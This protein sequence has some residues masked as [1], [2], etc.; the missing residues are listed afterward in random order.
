M[1]PWASRK[2]VSSSAFLPFPWNMIVR[3][4][5]LSCWNSI[6]PSDSGTFFPNNAIRQ[7]ST[8]RASPA[9]V[10][11]AQLARVAEDWAGDP[12]WLAGRSGSLCFHVRCPPAGRPWHLLHVQ[13]KVHKEGAT[14]I[15]RLWRSCVHLANIP[16]TAAN[17]TLEPTPWDRRVER[18][19]TPI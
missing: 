2:P 3:V 8:N 4:M 12:G 13:G 9:P 19:R 14:L 18:T 11:G 10:S 17:H 7:T 6:L 1:V 5:H 16:L 15:T